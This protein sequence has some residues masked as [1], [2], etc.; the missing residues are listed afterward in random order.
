[1]RVAVA[2]RCG[3]SWSTRRLNVSQQGACSSYRDT[4]AAHCH[5]CEMPLNPSSGLRCAWSKMMR[6]SGGFT[7][8]RSKIRSFSYPPQ[9]SLPA[10]ALRIFNTHGTH[11]YVDAC[12]LSVYPLTGLTPSHEDS[13]DGMDDY[14]F[15]TRRNLLAFLQVTASAIEYVLNRQPELE[16]EVAD[17][18]KSVRQLVGA[19]DTLAQALNLSGPAK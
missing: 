7:V 9:L 18:R 10:A 11:P 16:N 8:K 15:F 12:L 6:L 13:G 17:A 5:A 14:P 3:R 2:Q 1:M 4:T 19:R